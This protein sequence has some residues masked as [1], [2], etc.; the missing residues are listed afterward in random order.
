VLGLVAYARNNFLEARARFHEAIEIFEKLGD[1]RNMA[2]VWINLAR[3][4]YR[5]GEIESARIFIDKSLTLLDQLNALWTRGLALEILGLLKRKEGDYG[6]ALELFQE[7]LK[8]SVDQDNRQGIAN[9]L[10]AIAGLA[11]IT[12]QPGE[13]IRLFAASQKIREE[14]GARMGSE[15]LVEYNE[16]LMVTRQQ[17]NQAEYNQAW[18][19]GYH[20]S[21]DQAVE[22]ASLISYSLSLFPETKTEA[23]Y[24]A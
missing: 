1:R 6:R 10:G 7:S 17:L 21:I 5:Q 20:L 11:M 12:N 8:I 2:S 9:C 14:I 16:Y 22:D 4:A 13:A 18:M 24:G 3:T 19:N 23:L 15:D